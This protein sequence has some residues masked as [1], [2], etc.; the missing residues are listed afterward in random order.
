MVLYVLLMSLANEQG[1]TPMI[2]FLNKK[3]L[4]EEKLKLSPLSDIFPD[5]DGTLHPL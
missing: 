3:D 5:F 1:E 4:F 2:L